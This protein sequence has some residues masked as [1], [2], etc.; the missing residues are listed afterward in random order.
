M[1]GFLLTTCLFFSLISTLFAQPA[2]SPLQEIDES[3][4]MNSKKRT[5]SP[6][7]FKILELDRGHLA[8]ILDSAPREGS[9]GTNASA[10]FEMLL[11]DGTT[12]AFHLVEYSMIEPGLAARFPTFKT[13]HGYGVE[14]PN[15]RIR[16]DWTSN[17]LNVML[18]LPQGTAYIK[19]YSQGDTEHYLSYFERDLPLDMEPFEC[20]TV[21]DKINKSN[22][23]AGILVAGDC[24]LRTYRLAV[25]V[26]GEYATNT[27]GASSAGNA[28]DDALL[29]SHITTSINQINSYYERDLGT[30]F[31]LIAN[32]TDIFYYDGATDP[33][34]NSN[35]FA[36]LGEN[37]TN[38][39]ATIGSSNYDIG[40]VLAGS[41][42]GSGGIA[43]VGVLCGSSKAGGVTQAS[44]NGITQPRFLKVWAHE[45]GH[46]FGATHTQNENCQRS[47][48]SAME[49]GAG[50]TIM[51]YVTSNCDNQIQNFPEYYFHA[52]SIQQ[53][54]NTLLGT[55]CAAILPSSNSAPTVSAGAN[56]SVPPATPLLLE[57]I[58]NDG[59]GDPLTF[60]WEQ[61]DNEMA[62]AIPPAST[63][64]QGPNFRSLF[65]SPDNKR[66][67]PN[68][69]AVIAGTTPTWEVLPSVAR[70]MDFRVTVRD[71]S[72]NNISC[73]AE[74][75]IRITTVA[76]NP[77]IVTSPTTSGVIW[78][79][80]QNQT[81]IW[82]VAGTDVGPVSCD[83]VDILLSYDGGFTY[84]AALA[85][86]V[87]N[88]GSA[89]IIVPATGTS[90]TARVQVRCSNNIFYNISA[91]DFEIQENQGPTFT[92]N[93]PDPLAT[94]CPGDVEANIFLTTD[95][96]FGFTGDVT[97]SASNLPGS[98]L[99]TFGSTI[100]PAGSATT[101]DITNTASIAAGDYP[102]T[103][104]GTSGSIVRDFDFILTVQEGVGVTT[105]DQPADNAL[106]I[107]SQPTL[108]WQSKSNAIDYTVQLSEDS[109]FANLEVN[110]TVTTNFYTLN[111]EL[112]EL[113]VYYWRVKTNTT[114]GETTWSL[115]RNFTTA[116]CA[117]PIVQNTPVP[118]SEDGIQ[119]IN[120]ELTVTGTGNV[121]VIVVS[122]V[123]GVHTW[124][125]DLVVTLIA[126]DGV[127]SAIL[128]NR[129][130]GNNDDFNLSLS[131][132]ATQSVEEA[133]CNPLGQGGAYIPA[134]PL[135][136]FSGLPIAGVW[137]L[138]INDVANADGGELTSWGLEFC[139][140]TALPVDL[141]SFEATGTK[142]AIQLDWKTADEFN[143]EGFEIER[144]TENERDF[145]SI[146]EVPATADPQAVNQY[147]FLDKNVRPGIQYY[148]RLRQND[149]DG[150]FEYSDIRT[151]R[152]ES[153]NSGMQVYPSPVRNELFGLLNTGFGMETEL[154]LYDL[155]GRIIKEQV[156]S[157]NEFIM[158]MSGLPAGV[159]VLKARYA[160]G[161][162]IVKVV[163]E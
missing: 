2:N 76:G 128:W 5:I 95:A 46:Q 50:T 41:T 110:E 29:T 150:Q 113:T 26:N 4:I 6:E 1:K 153:T 88:N 37:V 24:Q 109:G 117:P 125:G 64:I 11:S 30:R 147:E 84:P 134:E 141:L 22:S 103:I 57:A 105:L 74:D 47:S 78:F 35:S 136:V 149:F 92:L 43:N 23:S 100:I 156:A 98:A 72:T 127:T 159:Y 67:L 34:N 39:N 115:T 70:T 135:S 157:G 44:A 146:G 53:M 162:E 99:V 104:T 75:D 111:M 129:E 45:M 19:P 85:S 12:E 66:Y 38:L 55:S 10:P 151:A 25:A 160:S 154:R 32:L 60:T 17:G 79:E 13:Y 106:G 51:S 138:R 27:L 133:P 130:C 7:K 48:V 155:N 73:T 56:V 28:A 81:V 158:D 123:T 15:R 131:D 118:I 21:E 83:N 102:I 82:D 91:A 3:L 140:L 108:V 20:G 148:Y 36:M 120:S 116:D 161:E 49:P 18:K 87:P 142:N 65:P 52:I 31:I 143:N 122:N 97:F 126:P 40:H 68:L 119:E 114:C 63:N 80:S 8:F 71:N 89:N 152:I 90:T 124:M 107:V 77:F 101:F 93:L 96:V 144:R 163:V 54:S 9:T 42:G 69:A 62:E 58:A 145:T 139:S 112:E 16:L 14:D 94:I 132:N 59:D 137:T 86:N 121:D 61:Y 33:Y